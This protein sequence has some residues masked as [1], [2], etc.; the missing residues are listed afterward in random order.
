MKLVSHLTAMGVILTSVVVGG[1]HQRPP[2]WDRCHSAADG[3]AA[4]EPLD[5]T[6][7]NKQPS[8]DSSL[9]SKDPLELCVGAFPQRHFRKSRCSH[10]HSDRVELLKA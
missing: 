2:C 6:C 8:A 5:G 9:T 7:R 10:Q 3:A 4:G 1:R